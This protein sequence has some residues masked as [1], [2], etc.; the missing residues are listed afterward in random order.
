MIMA[1]NMYLHTYKVIISKLKSSETQAQLVISK[2]IK[3][4]FSISG[5]A[6]KIPIAKSSQIYLV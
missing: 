5:F 4:V 6:N 2:Q 1:I 3:K